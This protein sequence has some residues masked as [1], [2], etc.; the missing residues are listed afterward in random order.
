MTSVAGRL[1]SPSQAGVEEIEE[2][3]E[4]LSVTFTTV[5][6]LFLL[7]KEYDP[8]KDFLICKGLKLACCHPFFCRRT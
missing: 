2:E 3:E 8:Q 1:P 7:L 4:A 6:R 5:D